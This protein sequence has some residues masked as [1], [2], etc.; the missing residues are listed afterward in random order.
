MV[1][2]T[3]ID[4]GV[5]SGV[6]IGGASDSMSETPGLFTGIATDIRKKLST[7]MGNRL[8][9]DNTT[10]PSTIPYFGDPLS[11]LILL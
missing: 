7:D 11:F 5:S 4:S 2:D 3:I 1:Q 10:T 9:E 8:T 6:A